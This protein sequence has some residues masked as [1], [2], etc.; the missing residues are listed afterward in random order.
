ML[1]HKDPSLKYND[2][3]RY[4]QW[5]IEDLVPMSK[6]EH[7]RLHSTG[8]V[9]SEESRQKMSKWQKGMKRSEE[10]RN[11]CSEGHK[12]VLHTEEQKRKISEAHKGMHHSEEAK[13]KMREKALGRFKGK[14]WKLI[15]G[16][17]VW[18]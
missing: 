8:R 13:D 14:H 2:P 15:D 18:Y 17:R 4:F 16:K 5:R 10:F 1:H 11:K 6:E 12:G 3:E 7:S 9:Y